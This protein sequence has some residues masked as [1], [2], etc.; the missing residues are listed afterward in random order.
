MGWCYVFVGSPHWPSS[1]ITARLRQHHPAA[2]GRITC[3]G[4]LSKRICLPLF[5]TYVYPCFESVH[6]PLMSRNCKPPFEHQ[7]PWQITRMINFHHVAGTVHRRSNHSKS[8]MIQLWKSTQSI[9]KVQTLVPFGNPMV[10]H[11]FPPLKLPFSSILPIR[12]S[13]TNPYIPTTCFCWHPSP[14]QLLKAA[15]RYWCRK[16]KSNPLG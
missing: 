4:Y 13:W 3:M 12:H 2:E 11:H 7:R 14:P 5:S 16:V 6:F 10:H 15:H 1:D 9:S 8:S